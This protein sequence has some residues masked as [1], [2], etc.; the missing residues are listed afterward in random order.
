MTVH[1][2][3]WCSAAGGN[4][5]RWIYPALSIL[6]ASFLATG[7]SPMAG[8]YA[9]IASR[10]SCDTTSR[11]ATD[12]C[13]VQN[14]TKPLLEMIITALLRV[15]ADWKA[16]CANTRLVSFFSADLADT[17]ISD[18]NRCWRVGA[19]GALFASQNYHWSS[20][21]S[22][23]V[24]RQFGKAIAYSAS[25]FSLFRRFEELQRKNI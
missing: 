20:R 15:Y 8:D 14:V 10:Y 4:D 19:V 2:S 22:S 3:L 13:C 12:S 17:S 25:P 23:H 21:R 6:A 11:T 24:A 9:V 16:T 1:T 18:R 7:V 5:N